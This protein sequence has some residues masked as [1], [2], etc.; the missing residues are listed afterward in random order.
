MAAAAEHTVGLQK[1]AAVGYEDIWAEKNDGSETSAMEKNDGSEASGAVAVKND[2]LETS[3][4]GAVTAEGKGTVTEKEGCEGISEVVAVAE[5][6]LQDGF[7]R[8]AVAEY[9]EGI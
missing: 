6:N 1:L 7:D 3:A 4:D 2:G 8:P 9:E 5:D